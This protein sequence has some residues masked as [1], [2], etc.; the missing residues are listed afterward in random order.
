M[1]SVAL[2]ASLIVDAA[3]PMTLTYSVVEEQPVG[4]EVGNLILDSDLIAATVT[5]SVS[6]QIY[7]SVLPGEHK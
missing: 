7:F 4:T 5:R 3:E 1:L 6:K 2:T